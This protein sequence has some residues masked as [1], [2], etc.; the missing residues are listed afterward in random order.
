MAPP[1]VCSGRAM[2]SQTALALLQ[3]RPPDLS[4]PAQSLARFAPMSPT[5]PRAAYPE[6]ADR[7]LSAGWG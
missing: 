3:G 2:V 5:V 1:V 7:E 6:T 4:I